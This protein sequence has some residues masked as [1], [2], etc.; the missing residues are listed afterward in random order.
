MNALPP[1]PAPKDQ[2]FDFHGATL[3]VQVATADTGGAYCVLNATHLSNRGPALHVHPLGAETFVVLEGSYTF[4]A[5]GNEI[6]VGPGEVVSIPAGIAHRWVAG[7][8]GGVS[9]IVSPPGLEE[10]FWGVSLESRRGPLSF[11]RE[12]EI[13]AAHGQDFLEEG[14]HWES[15]P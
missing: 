12:M 10:Y 8:T 13:G 1:P 5:D 14:T 4:F 7:P 6:D 11:A 3:S 2:P 15:N 9:V